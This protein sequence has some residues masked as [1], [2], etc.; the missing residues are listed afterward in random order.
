MR[1]PLGFNTKAKSDV[2][3]SIAKLS[4][5]NSLASKEHVL[6]VPALWKPL[7]K[8][9]TLAGR[10]VCLKHSVGVHFYLR[11]TEIEQELR[12]VR[13]LRSVDRDSSPDLVSG[14]Q[15]QLDIGYA[16]LAGVEHEWL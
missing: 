9:I 11:T 10:Q 16:L 8:V 2:P 5:C 12:K 7:Q 15:L 13:S 14:G 1:P 3:G 6:H 4:R